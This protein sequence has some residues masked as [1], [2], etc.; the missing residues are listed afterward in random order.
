M[1]FNSKRIEFKT[2]ELIKDILII[3]FSVLITIGIGLYLLTFIGKPTN[4][5]IPQYLISEP[6]FIYSTL[7]IGIGI[8]FPFLLK[9][10]NEKPNEINNIGIKN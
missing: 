10:R 7:I 1:L 4:P 8:L 5:L 2:E 9:R 6:F 3:L